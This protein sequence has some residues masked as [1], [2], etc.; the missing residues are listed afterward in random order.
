MRLFNTAAS[1]ETKIS[2]DVTA[3]YRILCS[4]HLHSVASRIRENLFG[5]YLFSSC[6]IDEV[7]LIKMFYFFT[8]NIA[9]R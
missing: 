2:D 6:I 3:N 5:V 7:D 1:R 9:N 8:Q 4:A